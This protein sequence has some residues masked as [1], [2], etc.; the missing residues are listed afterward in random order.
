[1]TATELL[2]FIRSE[3]LIIADT[4]KELDALRKQHIDLGNRYMADALL[5][6]RNYNDGKRKTYQILL[7]EA[8]VKTTPGGLPVICN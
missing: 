6:A 1:M 5:H 8:G 3:L 2:E 7:E 4:E